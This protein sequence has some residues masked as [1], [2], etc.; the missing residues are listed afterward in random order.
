MNG[1]QERLPAP[2]FMPIDLGMPMR[3]TRPPQME[4]RMRLRREREDLHGVSCTN[5]HHLQTKVVLQISNAVFLMAMT[6]IQVSATPTLSDGLRWITALGDWAQSCRAGSPSALA[7]TLFW[8]P[9]L[10]AQT[11]RHGRINYYC[12]YYVKSTVA[13]LHNDSIWFQEPLTFCSCKKFLSDLPSFVRLYFILYN[14]F[15]SSGQTSPI[16]PLPVKVWLLLKHPG[17]KIPST[18]QHLELTV[19]GIFAV[20][21]SANAQKLLCHA[22]FERNK[23]NEANCFTS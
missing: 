5:K 13:F 1:H 11:L 19:Y 22:T 18:W 7:A 20:W 17:V 15:Q 4:F 2:S 14:E 16:I 6:T 8:G 3:E 12:Q 9:A 23:Q 10:A 21:R